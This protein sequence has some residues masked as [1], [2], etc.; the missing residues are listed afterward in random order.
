MRTQDKRAPKANKKKSPNRRRKPKSAHSARRNGKGPRK[1][2]KRDPAKASAEPKEREVASIEDREPIELSGE[3]A[4]LI[5]EIQYALHGEG[6]EKPTPIQSQAI[7]PQ[8]EGKDILGSAQTGTGKTAAFTIP[9]L[10]Q[11]SVDYRRSHKRR[12]KVLIL[13]PTRELAAQIGDSIATYGTFLPIEHTV[14]FGGVKQ[15]PQERAMDKGVDIVVATPGRLL[16]LMQQRF[17]N[18]SDVRTFVLDE[19]DRMLDMGFIRD[20]NRILEKLPKNRRTAFFSATL[21]PEIKKLANSMLTDPVRVSIDPG[22]PTVEKIQQRVLFIDPKQ[23]EKALVQILQQPKVGRAIV[24][25]QMKYKANRVTKTLVDTG[26]TA[27]PIH[28]NRSQAARTKA[29]AGFRSG[30]IKVLV[31]TDI[32]ARGID[33]DGVSDVV[34]F[35]LPVEAET[36]VHRIGRTARAGTDG[37]AW[38]L[39]SAEEGQQLRD[40]ERLIKKTIPD[41]LDHDL[42]SEEA[43]HSARI[44]E[45]A[46]RPPVKQRGGRRSSPRNRNGSQRPSPRGR[47]AG[48]GGRKSNSSSQTRRPRNSRGRK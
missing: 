42:H 48:R 12:P 22:K 19:A 13:A 24:F 2:S 15:G 10:Q 8:L 30:E 23:K 40:I 6:Y 32:A 47:N 18:L 29:L 20:I 16:D 43:F 41:D 39:C 44:A 11:L 33:V 34:N 35:D 36:Y 38:T 28:G 37:Q 21:S 25:T 31:A 7:P 45:R 17:V 26:I 9:I 4:S 3:F 27:A 5:P 1:S 14:I 46:G